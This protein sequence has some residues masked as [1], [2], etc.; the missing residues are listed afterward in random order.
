MK[1]NAL[2]KHEAVAYILSEAA[3]GSSS[4]SLADNRQQMRLD[5]GS[6]E[7]RLCRSDA[8]GQLS[9]RDREVV[10]TA[11][12]ELEGRGILRGELNGYPLMVDRGARARDAARGY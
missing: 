10:H 8:T 7:S 9:K 6:I 12:A 3:K 2:L 5:V 11:L 1:H 4:S